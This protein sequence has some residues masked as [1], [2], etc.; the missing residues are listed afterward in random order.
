MTPTTDIV[1]V[2]WNTGNLLRECL[3][4]IAVTDQSALA[5][6]EVVVVDN[7]S[8]DGSASGLDVPGMRLR[9]VH[10]IGNRG[11]AAAC[12][13]GATHCS[14]G[15]LL[16]LNPDTRLFPDTL[17]AAGEFLRTAE[18]VG[19]GICGARMID[20]HGEPG[21]SCSRLPTLRVYFGKMTGLDHLLPAIFPPH[22]LPPEQCTP[23][24]VDQVIG[25]FYLV[26]RALFTDLGGFD[27]RYF[28][29]FEE[30]DFAVRASRIG[31]G[32]YL[33]DGARVVHVGNVSTDQ[34]R[35]ERLG[36]SLCSRSLFARRHWPRRRA[37]ALV[38]LSLSVE[39]VARLARAAS[40]RS[41]AEFID[42]L[43]GYRIFL[44]WL[45][46]R[47]AVDQQWPGPLRRTGDVVVGVLALTV[48]LP[49]LV[50]LALLIR[51][52]SRGPALFRQRRVGQD[53]RE[54]VLYKFRSMGCDVAGPEVTSGSDPRVTRV[55]RLLRRT[56]LDEL[57]QLVNLVR[58]D[59][60]LVG[61]R[62]ETPGLARRYAPECRWVLRYRPGITGPVQLRSRELATSVEGATDPEGYYLGVLVPLRVAIDADFLA[63]P[64][65]GKTLGVLA[66]TVRY[67]LTAGSLAGRTR[68][69]GRH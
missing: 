9:V 56:G 28:L 8:A 54:F 55:G 17:R 34:V 35:A 64:S 26:R 27:E 13:Q 51:V 66:G 4:S 57:P 24:Q 63:D 33:L 37:T 16:F 25:A 69:R 61:P 10:N 49:V 40:H 48:L 43:A 45:T 65:L 5:V 62:P 60:T 22:H 52:T 50:A 31:W 53:G 23:G 59:V 44:R 47:A 11:F 32:S 67:T 12:N 7:A 58:G 29:Y 21:I 46:R 38:A 36:Y 19:V 20:E 6:G 14:S 15:Y 1:I 2:N 3:R 41:R 42:T 68:Q 39:P 18:A 30:V